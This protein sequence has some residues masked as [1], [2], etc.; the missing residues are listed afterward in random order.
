MIARWSG[1]VLVGFLVAGCATPRLVRLDTGAGAPIVYRPA[2]RAA[3]ITI[4]EEAFRRAMTRLVLDV[5]FSVRAERTARP[6][7]RLAAVS[8][9]SGWEAGSCSSEE[10]SAECLSLVEGG[11]GLLD[12]TA[13]R[14]LAL[15]F[16]W[17]GVWEGVRGAVGEMANPLMLQAMVTSAFAA[18]MLLLVVPE[19]VTKV[20]ALA[21]TTYFVAYLGLE[22]FFDVVNGWQ[23]LSVESER[24]V[25]LGEVEE[26]GHR[27]GEVMGTDGARVIILALTAALGGGAANLASK[28][29]MLPGFAQAA[30]AAETNAGF[31][32]AAVAT[33]GIRSIS[34]AEGVLTVGLVPNAVAMVA[35]GAG[36]GGQRGGSTGKL[37]ENQLPDRLAA[38]LEIARKL[39]VRPATVDSPDFARYA[40]T[41]RIKWV[42]TE[43]G[44]LQIVPHTWQS[45]E[46]THAVA[47][48]GRPVLAA[49]EA[50]LSVHG[51]VRFGIRITPRSGHYLK[52]APKSVSEAVLKIGR[53]AFSQFGIVFP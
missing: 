12:A 36:D 33:G 16:A 19:P 32:L 48:G 42:V 45:V 5:R 2:A 34:V 11:L 46:I 23:R 41:E 1:V 38:E 52:G 7:V 6:R 20:L 24:A 26:A 40:K 43:E 50:E 17:E 30:L 47:S 18:Y 13:R 4:D 15:S 29:P 51:S 49:G 21:L 28:G 10:G 9:S 31:R 39:G 25:S 14:D 37:L 8:S 27:F 53:Q 44:Q 3:P 35:R 22:V